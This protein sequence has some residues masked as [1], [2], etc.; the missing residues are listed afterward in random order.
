M[1]LLLQNFFLLVLKYLN[2]WICASD[3]NMLLG[4][5]NVVGTDFAIVLNHVNQIGSWEEG[6]ILKLV[7]WIYWYER[8]IY[9]I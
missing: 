5:F 8:N 9:L 6:H 2:R 1:F 3:Y 7:I 4:S